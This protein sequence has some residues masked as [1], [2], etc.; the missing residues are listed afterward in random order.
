MEPKAT[1]RVHAQRIGIGF[2]P[3]AVPWTV[4]T[5][6]MLGPGAPHID[7]ALEQDRGQQ[8]KLAE[9]ADQLER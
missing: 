8:A 7:T 2:A 9:L 4:Q 3:N 1:R 6:A 5:Q